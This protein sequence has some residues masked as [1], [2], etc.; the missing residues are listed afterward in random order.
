MMLD[1]RL[2][3]L[4]LMLLTLT[5]CE[6]SASAYKVEGSD[7]ALMLMR[8]QRYFWADEVEQAIVVARLPK[9]QRRVS[10]WPGSVDGPAMKVYEAGYQLWAL[11]QGRRWYLASTEKCR[12]QDWADAPATPPGALVGSFRMRDGDMVFEPATG[13]K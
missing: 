5:A 13:G 3:L 10:I 1:R 4:P 2:L 12:V 9:C 8:E 7:H 6:N 11:Q